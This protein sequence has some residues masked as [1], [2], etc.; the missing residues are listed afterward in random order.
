MKLASQ[1]MTLMVRSGYRRKLAPTPTKSRYQHRH[2]ARRINAL[3]EKGG[4]GRSY[5]EIG[6]ERG[7][8]FEAIN[9]VHKVCVDPAPLFKV[10]SAAAGAHVVVSTSEDY[11]ASQTSGERFDFVFLDGLHTAE[12]TYADFIGAVRVLAPGGMILI[13]DVLPSDEASALPSFDASQKKKKISGISHTRWYGDVWKVAWLLIEKYPEISVTLIGS[14]GS[15]HT[16]AIVQVPV[17]WQA[18]D[19]NVERDLTFMEGL[20][21]GDVVTDDGL[22]SHALP[23]KEALARFSS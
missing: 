8:T 7:L 22:A 4:S 16:Q 17:G 18:L 10:N 20:S 13:D 11:F 21:F 1:V 23:E 9:A 15:D 14:G 6:V 12:A 19:A 5:L 3:L 2:S